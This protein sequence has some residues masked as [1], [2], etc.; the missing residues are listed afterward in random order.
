MKKIDWIAVFKNDL[1]C[2]VFQEPG[3]SEDVLYWVKRTENGKFHTASSTGN[4]YALRNFNIYSEIMEPT[5]FA[6]EG[7]DSNWQ[8]T[9]IVESS[10]DY[11]GS[12]CFASISDDK[13][14]KIDVRVYGRYASHTNASIADYLYPRAIMYF[15]TYLSMYNDWSKFELEN[16]TLF[17]D[18]TNHNGIP[19]AVFELV[20][21]PFKDLN[22]YNF[23]LAI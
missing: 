8:C 19:S 9:S 15:L 16:P 5:L 12:L 3:R 20:N 23:P 21:E 4:T 22:A 11:W 6:C 2:K 18:I 14:K 7:E 1:S 17:D 10:L 13:G